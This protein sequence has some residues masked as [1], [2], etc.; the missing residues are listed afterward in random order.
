MDSL[1]AYSLIYIIGKTLKSSNKKP[2]LDC[3][4]GELLPL[5]FQTCLFIDP[6]SLTAGVPV[7]LREDTAQLLQVC[8]V[9]LPP[10]LSQRDC[11]PLPSHSVT[12]NTLNFRD[13]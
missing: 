4:S 3:Q 11:Q 9:N 7:P 6:D 2:D 13:Y 5:S 10:I 12:R 1:V 8:T